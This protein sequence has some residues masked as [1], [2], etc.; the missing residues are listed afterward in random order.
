M[1]TRGRG[2]TGPFVAFCAAA[3]VSCL[4]VQNFGSTN[5]DAP[6]AGTAADGTSPSLGS[7]PP[8]DKWGWAWAN[9]APT[10]NALYAI[11]GTS[12]EDIWV[13]GAG[14]IAHYNGKAWDRQ[15]LDPNGT[16]YFAIGVRAAND[17]WVAGG[18]GDDA[19]VLHFDGKDWTESYPFA[20]ALFGGFSHGAGNRLFA[21]VNLGLFELSSEGAWT[22][23]DTGQTLV[24]RGPVSDVWVAP[25]NDAWAI[26]LGALHAPT[27]LHAAPGSQTWE[28]T[29]PD[30]PTDAKGLAIS[31]AGAYGCAFYN[32]QDRMAV[33]DNGIGLLFYD[34]KQWQTGVRAPAS[35]L[36]Q[37]PQGATSACLRGG[38]GIIVSD[39]HLLALGLDG[40][41]VENS[42]ELPIVKHAAW[43]FDGLHG[44]AVGDNGL[45]LQRAWDDDSEF[46]DWKEVGPTIRN[47]LYDVDVGLDGSV[48]AVDGLRT[49]VP[50]GGEVLSWADRWK[51][52]SDPVG[53]VGPTVPV[54]DTVLGA[55]DAWIASDE[56][57]HIGVTHFT[58]DWSSKPTLLDG[59]PAEQEDALAI[60]APAANDVW[61]TG[62]ER[63]PDASSAAGKPCSKALASF[64]A[65]FDGAKWSTFATESAYVSIHGTGSNDV[66]FAGAGVA[67]WD[68]R[69]LTPVSTLA[70]QFAGVWSSV[71]GRVWL[72][73]ESSFLYDGTTATPVKKALGSSSDW[74][75]TG[76]AE[77]TAGDVFVLT[78]RSVGTT[79]LWFDPSRTKLVEQVSSD[80][81]LTKIK[82]RGNRL[83]AIGP[84]GASLRFEPPTL[85]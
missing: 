44:Y 42:T 51:A 62:R 67:H 13:A 72:W 12:D 58:G 56:N 29:G 15:R 3:C 74:K 9:P 24:D 40:D 14:M 28:R 2:T 6:D 70:G 57:G 43:S 1:P 30:L 22:A 47:D 61:L 21:I 65:H 35:A 18:S 32:N 52:I 50:H 34:Q 8:P 5:S 66:W 16:K 37:P 73:G 81:P 55:K 39:H 33:G 68:G 38:T 23:S 49:I 78:A 60:W 77:S 75:V 17:V 46:D 19:H 31:G 27:L 4:S 82:G 71:V 7:D 41:R 64:A 20:G 11:D 54:A 63:C 10:G 48:L 84:G 79:L 85:H 76:I 59:T 83:W 25:S 69:S 53:H 26:T 80:M 45:V 36:F